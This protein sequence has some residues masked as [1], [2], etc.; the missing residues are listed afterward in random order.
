MKN[1]PLPVPF[2]TS[3]EKAP[4]LWIGIDKSSPFRQ[5]PR[6]CHG[7]RPGH[8]RD[9]VT[10][11]VWP[12]PPSPC[13]LPPSQKLRRTRWRTGANMQEA[14]DAGR[15]GFA[16]ASARMV[17]D[18]QHRVERAGLRIA[19]TSPRD[20]Q[21]RRLQRSGTSSL[22]FAPLSS[23]MQPDLQVLRNSMVKSYAIMTFRTACPR[24]RPPRLTPTCW[25]F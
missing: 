5:S 18:M 8:Q 20:A 17:A 25:R 24:R 14:V 15:L 4:D 23:A 11:R 22:C 13:W 12:V 10:D 3:P 2:S 9:L 1:T 19:K 16:R 21:R 6:T 7:C